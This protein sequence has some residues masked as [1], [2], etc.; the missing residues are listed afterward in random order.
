MFP[1]LSP[2]CD[3]QTR[4]ELFLWN[5]IDC[6]V[7]K[8]IMFLSPVAR[9]KTI[10]FPWTCTLVSVSFVCS[11][12]PFWDNYTIFLCW[13]EHTLTLCSCNVTYV[14]QSESKL[15]SCLNVKELLARNSPEIWNLSDCNW[16]RT[17]NEVSGYGF[18][19]SC[20]H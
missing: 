3:L 4:Y 8:I 12:V 6:N 16:T 13:A 17:R 1:W 18:E 19:S 20:S 9:F 2:C 15:Y 11:K 14:F 7:L 10:L 5:L